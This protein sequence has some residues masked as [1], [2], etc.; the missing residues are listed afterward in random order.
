MDVES[1]RVNQTKT[2]KLNII[3]GWQK[4][5]FCSSKTHLGR[6]NWLYTGFIKFN[7]QFKL[8]LLNVLKIVKYWL[9][10]AKVFCQP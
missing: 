2:N 5:F 3:M 7:G 1:N 6:F 8:K 4:P 10:W 9:Y